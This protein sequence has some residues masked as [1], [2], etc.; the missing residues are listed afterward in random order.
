MAI[1]GQ[2]QRG[3]DCDMIY[4]FDFLARPQ[5][6]GHLQVVPERECE[7]PDSTNLPTLGYLREKV[8]GGTWQRP[9][10]SRDCGALDQ[11]IGAHVIRRPNGH[12]SRQCPFALCS[13]T[14]IYRPSHATSIPFSAWEN[15][16]EH[17]PPYYLHCLSEESW[18]IFLHPSFFSPGRNRCQAAKANL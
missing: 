8:L 1:E 3:G 15:C 13:L 4:R 18:I 16:S 9:I 2:L 5:Q 10:S 6:V 17:P 12:K 7:K 11:A 14:A